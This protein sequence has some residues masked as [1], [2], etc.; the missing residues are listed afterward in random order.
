MFTLDDL[1]STTHN[2]F[3]T[4]YVYTD[5][6]K[7][8]AMEPDYVAESRNDIHE[9]GIQEIYVRAWFVDANWCLHVLV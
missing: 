5:D 1:I 6:D 2:D 8:E 7:Y 9:Y 4:I 3:E